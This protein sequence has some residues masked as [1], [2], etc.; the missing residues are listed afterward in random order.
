MTR[1]PGQSGPRRH[2]AANAI[3][4]VAEALF[5][6]HGTDGVSLRQVATAAGS[7]NNSAVQY[8]FG[9]KDGL[10]R[11]IFERRLPSLEAARA[12]RLARAREEGM[13][14]DTATL[15]AALLLPIAEERDSA[16]RCSFAA[17]LLGLRLFGDISQWSHYAESAQVTRE[18]DSCLR[19]SAASLPPELFRQRLLHAVSVFLTAVVDWDRGSSGGDDRSTGA[20]EAFLGATLDFATAGLLAPASQG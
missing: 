10:I 20:R 1:S 2:S 9:S 6:R 18:L 16:G 4:D 8:H 17:F 12:E 11:G 14:S 19:A 7:A 13:D 3:L 5:G 15:L